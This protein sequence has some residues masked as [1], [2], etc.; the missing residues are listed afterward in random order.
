MSLRH[1]VWR[2]VIII[3]NHCHSTCSHSVHAFTISQLAHYKNNQTR[4]RFVSRCKLSRPTSER[5][6]CLWDTFIRYVADPGACGMDNTSRKLW[7]GGLEVIWSS[8]EFRIQIRAIGPHC[9]RHCACFVHDSV[10]DC[11]RTHSVSSF[12]RAII[13]TSLMLALFMS[14]CVRALCARLSR[15]CTKV[16]VDQQTPLAH[17]HLLHTHSY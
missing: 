3:S 8:A 7:P 11:H 10:D 9:H 12:C 5:K 2:T 17:C 16:K 6:R 1:L 15:V 4:L 13:G 14:V